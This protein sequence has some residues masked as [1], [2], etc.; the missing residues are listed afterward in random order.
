MGIN[1]G[2]LQG[3]GTFSFQAGAAHKRGRVGPAKDEG[4]DVHHDL[5]HKI[6]FQQF[7]IQRPAAFNQQALHANLL[8]L[9]QCS[10]QIHTLPLC[11]VNLYAVLPQPANLIRFSLGRGKDDLAGWASGHKPALHR[12]R[13]VGNHANFD[14]VFFQSTA[15]AICTQVI[16]LNREARVIPQERVTADH[17]GIALSAQT[18][19]SLRIERGRDPCTL[20]G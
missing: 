20:T 5:I 8:E 16:G 3:N 9:L 10:I 18:I 15:D 17:H 1:R 13:G 2:Q 7:L 12:Y 19:N 6:A 4:S 14:G 11:D